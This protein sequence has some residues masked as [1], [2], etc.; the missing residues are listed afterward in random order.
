[1]LLSQLFQKRIYT[2]ET[3]R[4]VIVGVDFSMKNY[5]IKHL[6]C[7]A[8]ER[9]PNQR[10][11]PDFAVNVSSVTAVSDKISLARIRPALPKTQ[12][13]LFP[14]LPVYSH[15]GVFLGKLKDGEMDGF[16]LV[17]LFTDLGSAF[18]PSSI[19]VCRD[20]IFLRKQLPY[21]LGQRVPSPLLSKLQTEET[22]I[23]KPLLRRALQQGALIKLTLS[24]PP[25]ALLSEQN[26]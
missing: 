7:S 1:M 20:A 3:P 11:S 21:P 8:Q 15:D 12:A 19:A 18:P 10:Q 2:G 16:T 26:E 23:T 25:F 13:K 9:S 17:Q 22:L 5:T 6:L 14:E 4:G 24:L